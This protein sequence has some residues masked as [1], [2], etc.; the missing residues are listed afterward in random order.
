MHD[1]EEADDLIPNNEPADNLFIE[2]ADYPYLKNGLQAKQLSAIKLA[3]SKFFEMQAR[4]LATQ[5]QQQAAKGIENEWKG[6]LSL[7]ELSDAT[8]DFQVLKQLTSGDNNN[9]S[10]SY[11]QKPPAEVKLQRK[12]MFGRQRL[13]PWKYDL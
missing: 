1:N 3:R 11:T 12:Q 8:F 6:I 4:Q 5:Q 13:D 2:S 9:S 7:P 10:V